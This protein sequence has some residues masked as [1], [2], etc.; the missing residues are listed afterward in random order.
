[1]GCIEDLF[2][3]FYSESWRNV[4]S[5]VLN[6]D[7]FYG[8]AFSEADTEDDLEATLEEMDSDGEEEVHLVGG[9]GGDTLEE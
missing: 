1:M 5:E 4:L 6:K 2:S 7:L 3:K 9:G 8:T